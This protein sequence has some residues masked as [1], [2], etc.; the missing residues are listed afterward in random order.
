MNWYTFW[1][2]LNVPGVTRGGFTVMKLELK[3]SPWECKGEIELSADKSP[4]VVSY[5]PI[6]AM[7]VHTI[8]RKIGK[9]VVELV[10]VKPAVK[11][12]V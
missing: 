11:V 4:E 12:H 5:R 2:V 8:R 6:E 9:A 1:L 7:G 10:R 3:S